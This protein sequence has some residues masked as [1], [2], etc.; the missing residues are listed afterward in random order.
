[1]FATADDITAAVDGKSDEVHTHTL[2]DVTDYNRPIAVD[3]IYLTAS[4][5][6]PSAALGYG[7]WSELGRDDYFGLGLSL[8]VWQRTA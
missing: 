3:G 6:D 7:T 1:V 4:G 8:Y 5:E 2:A